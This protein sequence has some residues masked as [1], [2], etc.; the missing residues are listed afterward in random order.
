MV[1]V[2]DF[3]MKSNTN[4]NK[5]NI[6]LFMNIIIFY[7]NKLHFSGYICLN[8]NP[9]LFFQTK[10]N[11][12]RPRASKI[13][14]SLFCVKTFLAKVANHV[15]FFFSGI[16]RMKNSAVRFIF[17]NKTFD[18]AGWQTLAHC[19]KKTVMSTQIHEEIMSD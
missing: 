4:Q 19:L 6:F 8:R 3:N 2:E 9:R 13:L 1:S 12:Y 15:C 18:V 17:F 16:K 11:I 14:R 5:K 10:I 7:Y